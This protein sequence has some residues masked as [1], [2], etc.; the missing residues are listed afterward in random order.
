MKRLNRY[1]GVLAL[2]AL[3]VSVIG[4]GVIGANA[5][6][7]FVTS[8]Q[9]KNGTI[10]TQDIHRNG[11]RSTDLAS[12]AVRSP[13]VKNDS[14]ESQ[15]IDNGDVG[16]VDIANGE[17]DGADLGLS[18]PAE[19]VQPETFTAT[20]GGDFAF[21]EKVVTYDKVEPESILEVTWVGTVA[22]RSKPV[23]GGEGATHCIFQLRVNGQPA[24]PQ[25]NGE[26]SVSTG[27]STEGPANVPGLL[28]EGL[29]IGPHNIEIWARAKGG[30][31]ECT[32]GPPGLGINQTFQIAE[33]TV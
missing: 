27:G 21:V 7:V 33:Q 15:D 12:G 4:A 6:G 8:K 30:T 28:F 24:S 9:I 18:P 14:I 3:V 22:G 5:A 11:V 17:V 10:V 31:A 29:G 25:S 2:C 19:T 23:P 13:D 26:V 16:S 32:V 1:A 20:V